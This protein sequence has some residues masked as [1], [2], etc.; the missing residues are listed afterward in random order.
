MSIINVDA[1]EAKSVAG[2]GKIKRLFGS[3]S[4]RNMSLA[5]GIFQPGEG[6]VLHDHPNEEEFYY[7]LCGSGTV[8]VGKQ[9]KEVRPGD[10][11]YVPAGTNH[12]IINT[13]DEEL[14]SVFILSPPTW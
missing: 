4:T 3:E 2:G 1:I 10:V 11:L 8:T 13:G 7:I 12:K 5:V 9:E 14:R 6:L